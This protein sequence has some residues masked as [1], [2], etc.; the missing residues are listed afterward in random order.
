MADLLSSGTLKAETT[1]AEELK[2]TDPNLNEI[3]VTPP[4]STRTQ[5]PH[6]DGP[7]TTGKVPLL[8]RVKKHLV[9]QSTETGE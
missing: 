2:M 5:V 7:K 9:K 1:R 3:P 4:D 8:Q 6:P